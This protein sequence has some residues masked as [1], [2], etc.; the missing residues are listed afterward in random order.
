M[1]HTLSVLGTHASRWCEGIRGGERL[2]ADT[3]A[4]MIACRVKTQ[5]QDGLQQQREHARG[6]VQVRHEA[7]AKRKKWA[8]EE[9]MLGRAREGAGV[10]TD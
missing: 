4:N 6:S 7:M 8:R 5:E 3:R 9:V 2:P 10:V 1:R